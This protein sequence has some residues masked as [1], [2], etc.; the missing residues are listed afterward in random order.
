MGTTK[1]QKQTY[2]SRYLDW[3]LASKCGVDLQALRV[4]PNAKEITE[5]FAMFEATKYL[6][7]PFFWNN[8]DVQCFCIGD[9]HKPRTAAMFAF[10]TAWNCFSV[11]PDLANL[12]YDVKRLTLV[13]KKIEDY[14]HKTD[15]PCVLIL[16]HSHAR[17]ED[18]L[19]SI[20]SP[21]KV[22]ITMDC[23]VNNQI[24]NREPYLEYEDNDVW[25][26][27]NKIRIYM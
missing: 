25:S 7:N 19:Q 23:C 2:R 15:K 21:Q 18:C 11:D 20:Q 24:P 22:I 13:R 6:C 8:P 26:P 10:R 16:P 4:F 17:I 12:M 14:A 1:T 3:F 5:S 27:K 9:G